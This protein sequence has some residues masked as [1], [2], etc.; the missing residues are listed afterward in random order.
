MDCCYAFG[1]VGV[2]YA[3]QYL[4]DGHPL[5]WSEHDFLDFVHRTNLL[6]GHDDHVKIDKCGLG[7]SFE[8]STNY[9]NLHELLL[10]EDYE[11]NTTRRLSA[12]FINVEG[13][14]TFL[15]GDG[16]SGVFLRVQPVLASI[17]CTPI[18]LKYS[19]AHVGIY[20]HT[21]DEWEKIWKYDEVDDEGFRDHIL[22][23][24][25]G[26]EDEEKHYIG[27]NC[28]GTDWGNDGFIKLRRTCVEGL[29]GLWYPMSF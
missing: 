1:I 2:M 22:L 17:R 3:S 25:Y 5:K 18:L 11:Y 7:N 13:D 20:D 29:G 23:L 8:N 15:V 26:E 14:D 9:I 24:G 19:N 16:N 12:K 4:S 27:K 6:F 21:E 10:N 28:W